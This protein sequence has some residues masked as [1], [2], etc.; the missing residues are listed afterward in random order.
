[1]D[2]AAVGAHNALDLV[3]PHNPCTT[4]TKNTLNNAIAILGDM[5]LFFKLLSKVLIVRTPHPSN[6]HF[7]IRRLVVGVLYGW[8]SPIL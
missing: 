8:Q 4:P 3:E 7:L 1:M 2:I 5:Y 6:Y